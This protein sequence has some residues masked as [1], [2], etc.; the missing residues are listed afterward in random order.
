M[1]ENDTNQNAPLNGPDGD[2]EQYSD[3]LA[4][5]AQ[6]QS[7]GK[8]AEALFYYLTAFEKALLRLVVL[9]SLSPGLASRL[10][11]RL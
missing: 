4:R 3:Y 1:F 10:G 11:A 5:A 6:A 2:S 7:L 9:P 8:K